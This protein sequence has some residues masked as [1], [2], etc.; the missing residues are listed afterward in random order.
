MLHRLSLPVGLEVTPTRSTIAFFDLDTG[1]FR[2][3]SRRRTGMSSTVADQSEMTY[4]LSGL[5]EEMSSV[6]DG[7][8][9]LLDAAVVPFCSACSGP[10]KEDLGKALEREGWEDLLLVPRSLAAVEYYFWRGAFPGALAVVFDLGESCFTVSVVKKEDNQWNVLDHREDA[11][12]GVG[13]LMGKVADCV[14]E[15]A[16]GYRPG[17]SENE[18]T[19]GLSA[20][21]IA[22]SCKA[23]SNP[24][25][26]ARV[27]RAAGVLLEELLEKNE[28]RSYLPDLVEIDG[29]WVSLGVSLERTSTDALLQELAE[30]TLELSRELISTHR[31]KFSENG[32][33]LVVVVDGIPF[34]AFEP[35]FVELGD[36]DGVSLDIRSDDPKNAV[37]Y[38]AAVVGLGKGMSYKTAFAAQNFE[39]FQGWD[40]SVNLETS[41]VATKLSYRLSGEVE[42]AVPERIVEGGT[43]L[44]QYLDNGLTEELFLDTDNHFDL[45]LDLIPETINT[46]AFSLCDVEGQEFLRFPLRI[47]HRGTT[48]R[49]TSLQ[50]GDAARAGSLLIEVL[51]RD[52]Q[53]GKQLVVPGNATWPA[54]F[55][56]TCHTAD[57]SGHILVPLY[58]GE[59]PVGQI[60]I[61]NVPREL[62]VGS[63]VDVVVRGSD[64]EQ[65]NVEVV[66]R[67]TEYQAHTTLKLF[68][69]FS[70]L[71]REAVEQ[72]RQRIREFKE[73]GPLE[74]EFLET[75]RFGT[76]Q[77]VADML[78][79]IQERLDNPQPQPTSGELTPRW[80]EFA[81]LVRQCLITAGE[82]ADKTG[83][84]RGELFEEVYTQEKYAEDAF[85]DNDQKLYSECI[86][87]LKQFSMH[88]EQ[89]QYQTR[90]GMP[91]DVPNA[92]DLMAAAADVERR[93]KQGRSEARRL[94]RD[95]L[96]A[97]IDRLLDELSEFPLRLQYHPGFAADLL[98]RLF[99]EADT[100]AK[101]WPTGQQPF[102]NPSRTGLLE[103]DI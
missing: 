48:V 45:E 23:S 31:E 85:A 55:R 69:E 72:W 82:V 15:R 47:H 8:G 27:E 44:I 37:V 35:Y 92:Q 40:V 73:D 33:P 80:S 22:T 3:A 17:D 11:N 87:N 28:C 95:D 70:P 5:R 101:S 14:L 62:G 94:Q 78:V 96:T 51:D 39:Q 84:D 90:G 88:L 71:E 41:P 6:V 36:V 50:G 58:Q 60:E 13:A 77:E 64:F 2:V 32:I 102:T 59:Q 7:R 97:K 63:P 9:Y 30:K 86:E 83:Q 52:G 100:I 4:S 91:L 93:L 65:F 99:Q 20:E 61:T 67:N 1:E 53:P 10:S 19:E 103:G 57:Q 18:P 12:L 38:G 89:M 66:V 29:G 24:L 54:E 42:M 75:V 46:F 74:G 26:R 79:R 76:T 49:P 25:N 56:C 81:K 43:V 68:Q 16:R 98:G 21:M 34:S